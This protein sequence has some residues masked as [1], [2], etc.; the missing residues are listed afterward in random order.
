MSKKKLRN[1][2]D[3]Y[4]S[5]IQAI[6]GFANFYAW[7]PQSRQ[8]R[9]G[10]IAFQGHK[11][12]SSQC[13]EELGEAD[14]KPYVTPDLGIVM[15]D[16]GVLAEVKMSFPND[17]TH[18]FD[19]FDQL[20]KYDADLTGW[21]SPSGIVKQHDIVLIVE[22]GRAGRVRK[23]FERH[24]DE[25]YKFARPFVIVQCNRSDNAEP[26]YFFQRV[27]G[28][29]SSTGVNDQLD[30]GTKVSM[31]LLLQKYATVKLYDAKPPLPYMVDLIWREVVLEIARM[32]PRFAKLRKRQR[33]AVELEV[34]DIVERL[35]QGF[36]F[37]SLALSAS[38][39]APAIPHRSWVIDALEHLVAI[40]DAEWIDSTK[41]IVR[42]HFQI[43]DDTL[44]YFIQ[45]CLPRD[46]S[47]STTQTQM[48]LPGFKD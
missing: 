26:Y 21:P 29:L 10:V 12:F 19:D 27:V 5:S 37:R 1:E 43:L 11:L 17:D 35:R 33:M 30:D 40:K 32:E 8:D 38:V 31:R 13:D 46:E 34:A 23:F 36:T 39:G 18:W 25:R 4:L 42:V 15:E 2:I 9:K 7:D 48:N 20:A 22:Q 28:S 6:V 3:D 14:K 45:A 41:E 44:D 47:K 24:K 16:L